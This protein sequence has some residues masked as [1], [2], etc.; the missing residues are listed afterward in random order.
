MKTIAQNASARRFPR[1]SECGGDVELCAKP[2]RTREYR[3]GVALDVPAGFKIPTCTQCGNEL[4]SAAIAKRL[5]ALLRPVFLERQASQLRVC[6]QALVMRHSV[7]QQQIEDACGV[8][9]SYLSHIISGRREASE[10]LMKLIEVFALS[11]PAFE[12][13]LEGIP[14]NERVLAI[15]EAPSAQKY[16]VVKNFG[17]NKPYQTARF[18]SQAEHTMELAS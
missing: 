4:M 16:R 14:F 15:F 1:C 12:F 8:T 5:D 18:M 13:A 10:P 6:V 11:A 2:G 3:R 7:T 9:R 17:Q